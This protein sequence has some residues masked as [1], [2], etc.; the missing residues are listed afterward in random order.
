M[1]YYVY[2][3]N[4]MTGSSFWVDLLGWPDNAPAGYD[5][6]CHYLLSWKLADP[7]GNEIPCTIDYS[8]ANGTVPAYDGQDGKKWVGYLPAYLHVMLQAEVP[9]G[10]DYTFTFAIECVG[11]LQP[12][13]SGT[14]QEIVCPIFWG[15]VQPLAMNYHTPE[16]PGLAQWQQKMVELADKWAPVILDPNNNLGDNNWYYDVPST[17]WQIGDYLQKANKYAA[18]ALESERRYEDY[19]LSC[20][21]PGGVAVWNVFPRGLRQTFERTQEQ[22]WVDSMEKL[23]SAG[24]VAQGGNPDP[25][26]MRETAYACSTWTELCQVDASNMKMLEQ[27]VDFL[28]GQFNLLYVQQLNKGQGMVNEPAFFG[29][30]AQALIDYFDLTRDKRIPQALET[31]CEYMWYAAVNADTGYTRYDI[32]DP[33]TEWFT[34]LNLLMVNAWGFMYGI[35]GNDL[36]RQQGDILFAH[37]FDDGNYQWQPKQFAQI[38]RRSIDYVTRWRA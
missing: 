24:W 10:N 18:V 6:Y 36:Y 25:T 32:F 38:F 21:P 35:T 7:L 19:L 23:T 27:T 5:A 20:Q 31:A 8:H 34:S 1:A 30:A 14:T 9:V 11:M 15:Q 33:H 3:P 12:L 28:L 4:R 16:I 17:Y 22:H 26:S 37:V 29:L 13:G 2:A